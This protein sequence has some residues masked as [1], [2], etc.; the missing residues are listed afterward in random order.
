MLSACQKGCI[1]QNEKL[2][3]TVVKGE[4]EPSSIPHLT[5]N[6]TPPFH[7][8]LLATSRS[9]LKHLFG[10]RQGGAKQRLLEDGLRG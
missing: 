6:V 1:Q 7:N 9:G 4:M 8:S 2:C 5:H 10:C 3:L